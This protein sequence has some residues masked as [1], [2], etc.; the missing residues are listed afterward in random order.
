VLAGPRNYDIFLSK[1]RKPSLII[2]ELGLKHQNYDID[3]G[4]IMLQLVLFKTVSYF[5]LKRRLNSG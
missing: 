3:V 4:M 2:R 1:S 5:A